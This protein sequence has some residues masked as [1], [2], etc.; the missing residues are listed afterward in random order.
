MQRGRLRPRPQEQFGGCWALFLWIEQMA[1][2]HQAGGEQSFLGRGGGS[3]CTP[4]PASPKPRGEA[5]GSESLC[6]GE[7]TPGRASPA[8]KVRCC[9]KMGEKRKCLM[10]TCT[11]GL[12]LKVTS[13]G[14]NYCLELLDISPPI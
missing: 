3:C 5:P 10:V 9:G 11:S 14:S 13:P 7:Q 6:A 8:H 12:S 2:R 1:D 4:L